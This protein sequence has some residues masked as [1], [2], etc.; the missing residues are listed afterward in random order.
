MARKPRLK[1]KTPEGVARF[2]RLNQP[3]TKFD[4]VGAYQ[5]VLRCKDEDIEPFINR[6]EEFLEEAA[7]EFLERKHL[8]GGKPKKVA[9]RPWRPAVDRVEAADGEDDEVEVPGYTDVRFKLK[10]AYTVSKGRPDERTIEQRPDLVDRYGRPIDPEKTLI[11]GGSTLVIGGFAMP[12]WMPTIGYGVSLRMAA[13]QVR[14]LR[15]GDVDA[16]AFG[17]ENDEAPD[18]LVP[19]DDSPGNGIDDESEFE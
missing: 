4:A 3:D 7:S 1:F 15:S 5:T 17:F 8:Q 6:I 9:D 19:N 10:A 11:F 2:P 18:D 12:F 13:V 14:E 16:S